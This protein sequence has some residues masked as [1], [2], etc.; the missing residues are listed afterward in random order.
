MVRRIVMLTIA[1]LVFAGLPAI[2][3]AG[4]AEAKV[5]HKVFV[6]VNHRV[7]KKGAKV[8]I[9]GSVLP[10]RSRPLKLMRSYGGKWRAIKQ[11]VTTPG[12]SYGF[13]D[14]V[15]NK[16]SR[17]YRVCKIGGSATCSRAVKVKVRGSKG[18]GGGG[19]VSQT[20]P[21]ITVTGVAAYELTTDGSYDISGTASGDLIGKTVY[22]QLFADS[23][24]SAISSAA[25]VNA[26]GTWHIVARANQAGRD[27]ALR[28]YAP[29]TR[30]T[31]SAGAG[32]SPFTVYGWYY[33]DTYDEVSGDKYSDSIDINGVTYP[34]SVYADSWDD[35]FEVN[36]SRACKTFSAS[37]GFSDSTSSTARDTSI[38]TG[39]SRELYRMSNVRLG[40]MTPLS[41]DIT[42][43]L[44]LRIEQV[45]DSGSA[46][47]VYGDARVLCAY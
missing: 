26:D 27:L 18:G 19:G 11:T 45:Q 44:R 15:T 20:Q 47:I 6:K 9:Y 13:T 23:A 17:Y 39:D 40:V 28:V 31:K 41:I 25:Y 35:Y 3:I 43:V 37:M 32:M 7:V 2:V 21:A 42:G 10:Q 1:A 38:I 46:S 14:K 8:R 12:G 22:L 4:S 34:R 24:W 36:L 30:T 5:S 16:R 29:A 33:L